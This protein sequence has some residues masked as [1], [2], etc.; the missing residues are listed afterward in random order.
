MTE[1]PEDVMISAD[2]AWFVCRIN[3]GKETNIIAHAIME[4]RDKA[5]EDAQEAVRVVW[6]RDEEISLVR[7]NDAIRAMKSTTI[8]VKEK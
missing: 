3:K 7:I 5:L 6:C 1:I 8:D 2:N 4:A